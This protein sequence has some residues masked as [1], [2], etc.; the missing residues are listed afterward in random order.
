MTNTFHNINQ[1]NIYTGLQGFTLFMAL[2]YISKAS[3]SERSFPPRSLFYEQ[4]TH[5]TF[6]IIAWGIV[7]LNALVLS[8]GTLAIRHNLA[9]R[10]AW[11]QLKGFTVWWRFKKN[12]CYLGAKSNH[13]DT[14]FEQVMTLPACTSCWRK[15]EGQFG[16]SWRGS[17][18]GNHGKWIRLPELSEQNGTW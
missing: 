18:F 7:T 6:C 16:T 1:K 17:R 11:I 3:Y 15:L 9:R 13:Y 8:I 10:D 2:K 14:H 12:S 4:A 5:L